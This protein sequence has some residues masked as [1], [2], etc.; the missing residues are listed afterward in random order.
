L[1]YL[2]SY[3][4]LTVLVALN[5]SS[6]PQKVNFGM[7]QNGFSSTRSLLATPKSSVSGDEVSLEPFG[8]LIAELTK[9]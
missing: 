2:R 5:M 8:V 7:S 3:K 6:T 4:G 1:S 9:K